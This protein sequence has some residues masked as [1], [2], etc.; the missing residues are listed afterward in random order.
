MGHGLYP[1]DSSFILHPSH[2]LWRLWWQGSILNL[3][4]CSYVSGEPSSLLHVLIQM[5]AG[6]G[7]GWRRLVY[8]AGNWMCFKLE[9]LFYLTVGLIALIVFEE[10]EFLRAKGWPMLTWKLWVAVQALRRHRPESQKVRRFVRA[11]GHVQL[12]EG[13]SFDEGRCLSI[14]ASVASQEPPVLSPK[15]SW[16]VRSERQKRQK[17]QRWQRWQRQ[18]W[19]HKWSNTFFVGFLQ[20]DMSLC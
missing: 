17:W 15:L 14:E 18:R 13:K 2:L 6:K 12:S 1:R 16:S 3:R 11:T 10:Q 20:S 9:I 4:S 8:C 19:I 7:L 5:M